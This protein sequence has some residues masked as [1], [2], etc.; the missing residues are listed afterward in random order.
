MQWRVVQQVQLLQGQM[1]VALLRLASLRS[2]LREKYGAENVYYIERDRKHR[3]IFFC[4]NKRQ[5]QAMKAAL[6]YKVEPYPKGESKRYD[7]S[8]VINN[9]GFLFI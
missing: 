9:Q 5:S 3:Y 6:K 2:F 8:A 7:A 4:G 1:T